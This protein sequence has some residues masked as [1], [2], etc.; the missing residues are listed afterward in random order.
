MEPSLLN[1]S[2][3]LYSIKRSLHNTGGTFAFGTS[4][5]QL[6]S[7][8]SI[9]RI[10]A[11]GVEGFLRNT[12]LVLL[13]CCSRVRYPFGKFFPGIIRPFFRIFNEVK[14]ALGNF[15]QPQIFADTMIAALLVFRGMRRAT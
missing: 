15:P 8:Q 6:S 12:A 10:S 11:D 5:M 2:I 1:G 13:W 9:F 14:K 4:P 7:L 3:S